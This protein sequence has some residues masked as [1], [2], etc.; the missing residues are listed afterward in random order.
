MYEKKKKTIAQFGKIIPY[1]TRPTP[2]AGKRIESQR[3]EIMPQVGD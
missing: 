1:W 2:G 3:P